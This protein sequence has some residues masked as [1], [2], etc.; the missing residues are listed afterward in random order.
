MIQGLEHTP[1]SSRVFGESW[2]V[3]DFLDAMLR[4]L[5]QV[6]PKDNPVLSLSVEGMTPLA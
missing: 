5:R 4:K 1:I 2:R 6:A 3:I